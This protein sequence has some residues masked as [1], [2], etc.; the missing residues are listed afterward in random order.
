MVRLPGRDELSSH[1]FQDEDCESF[2]KK[3]INYAATEAR[4]RFARGERVGFAGIIIRPLGRFLYQYLRVGS[5]LYGTKGLAYAVMNL[6]YDIN[7]AIIIWELGSEQT[8]SD[9]ILK[10]ESKRIELIKRKY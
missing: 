4:Q 9:S 6:I 3:T 5:F 1:L 2:T 8:L 10:N 7:I